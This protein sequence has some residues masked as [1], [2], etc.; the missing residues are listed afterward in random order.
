VVVESGDVTVPS[1]PPVQEHVGHQAKV[2]ANE[3]V[4]VSGVG[5]S[6]PSA[7]VVEPEPMK[8][9]ELSTSSEGR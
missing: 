9:E 5:D 7:S 3:S 1:P 8:R 4:E 6:L 2:S